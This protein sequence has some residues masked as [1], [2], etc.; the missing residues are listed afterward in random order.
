MACIE[1]ETFRPRVD[2]CSPS[3]PLRHFQ[4][5]VASQYDA[6]NVEYNKAYDWAA[7]PFKQ[8]DKTTNSV[9]QHNQWDLTAADLFAEPTVRQFMSDGFIDDMVSSGITSH[10]QMV[11]IMEQARHAIEG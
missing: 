11:S 9:E 2:V 1:S 8:W 6:V 3:N 5:K 4:K 7:N 10:E